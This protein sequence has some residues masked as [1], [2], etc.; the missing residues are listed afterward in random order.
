MK[1]FEELE[2]LSHKMELEVSLK[3]HHSKKSVYGIENELHLI[4]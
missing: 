2:H 1:I 3:Y 4:E